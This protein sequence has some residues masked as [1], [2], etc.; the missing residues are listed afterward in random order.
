[1]GVFT[2]EEALELIVLRG[3]VMQQ[4]PAGAMLSIPLEEK[5]L[6][7]LLE[8]HKNLSLAIVNGPSCL[9]AGTAEAVAAFEKEMKNR[10][11]LCMPVNIAHAAHSEL[12]GPAAEAFE[13]KI[14]E[15]QLNAPQIPYISNITG[16]WITPAEATDPVYWIRH[17]K[18]TVRFSDGIAEILNENESIFIEVGPGRDLCVLI[19]RHID[20]KPGNKAMDLV[21]PAEKKESDT[22]YL[23]NRLGRMW[24]NGVNIQWRNLQAHREQYRVP[25]PTY[26]FERK[27]V[28]RIPLPILEAIAAQSGG[29]QPP[30]QETPQA[31]AAQTIQESQDTRDDA[32]KVQETPSHALPET[33]GRPE[34]L[35]STYIP[36]A[37]EIEKALITIWQDLFGLAPIGISDD[38][39]ELGGDSLK[40][41]IAAT[42]IHKELNVEVA[43]DKLFR[44]PLIRDLAQLVQSSETS[45]VSAITP[46]PPQPFYPL[47]A[48][49]KR[50]YLIQQ[51][52]P[53]S[54]TYNMPFTMPLG[55]EIDKNRIEETL[56][57]IIQRHEVLRT[58]FISTPQNHKKQTALLPEVV[59]EADTTALSASG[60]VPPFEKGTGEPVQKIHDTVQFHLEEID[61]GTAQPEELIAGFVKPFDLSKPPLIRSGII[62]HPDNTYTWIGDIHH[63]V[64]DGTSQELLRRE[65]LQ[66]YMDQAPPPL[67]IQYKDYAHWQHSPEQQENAKKQEAYWLT[68]LTT[69]GLT[70]LTSPL[71]ALDMPLDYPRPPVQ[72]SEGAAIGFFLSDKETAAIKNIS[73]TH[74]VTLYMALIS[75][76]YILLA[77]LS[78]QEDITVGTITAGRR[79]ADLQ[80]VI[81]VFIN[82]M[83]LRNYPA[84]AKPFTTFLQE[85]KERTLTAFDNQDYQFDKLVEKIG[86]KREPGRSPVFDVMFSLQ[87]HVDVN[88]TGILPEYTTEQIVKE[89]T[90]A[91]FDFE[92]LCVESQKHIYCNIEYSTNLFKRETIEKIVRYYREI[93][94]T[95][96]TNPEGLIGQIQ[97]S[98]SFE[99]TDKKIEEIDDLDFGF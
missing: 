61:G 2:L 85:V 26:P 95:V 31:Q 4:M 19:R 35:S 62:T 93:I 13:R 99:A 71:P 39:F 86:T 94:E 77:R 65:F 5:E 91:R 49:Q 57:K 7:P 37:N 38:F 82:T 1:A 45:V 42:R 32:E 34:T 40:A 29:L 11:I 16:T 47:S 55:S 44:T 46:A 6:L 12:M 80:N 30:A 48:A 69:P 98:H 58:A 87:S 21:K 56:K 24:L 97:L 27:K 18:E 3:K 67:A 51:M 28:A 92:L 33:S 64:T 74:N 41:I 84:A 53:A 36:P 9:I 52:D 20:N 10:R 15:T 60:S 88:D 54:T 76:Y 96:S 50:L 22:Y 68:E 43:I 8:P 25:L 73:Q 75:L 23:L 63:I 79:H 90:K 14:R 83:A 78:G 59:K 72:S 17:M 89:N 81:G 70:G 66:I